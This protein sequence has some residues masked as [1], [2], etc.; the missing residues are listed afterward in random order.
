MLTAR[1]FV[2]GSDELMRELRNHPNDAGILIHRLHL[3]QMMRHVWTCSLGKIPATAAIKSFFDIY[4]L[5]DDDYS[6][7]SAYRS[8]QRFRTDFDKV[9]SE[10]SVQKA[11]NHVRAVGRPADSVKTKL[12]DT[13]LDD[14]AREICTRLRFSRPNTP[15]YLFRQVMMHVYSTVGGRSTEY[16]ARRFGRSIRRVNVGKRRIEG[17][18][19]YD[20]GFALCFRPILQEIVG[21][22]L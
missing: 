20:E 4:D 21:E 3:D 7:E 18:L 16:I 11:A 13:E 2:T 1:I 10:K 19:A 17:Y 6:I 12:S 8:W 5:C 14:M 15:A 9:F 22:S